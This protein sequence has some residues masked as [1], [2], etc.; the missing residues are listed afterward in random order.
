MVMSHMQQAKCVF[1]HFT[2]EFAAVCKRMQVG[3]VDNV[4]TSG[5]TLFDR[6]GWLSGG[7]KRQCRLSG[8]STVVQDQH[9][10]L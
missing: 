8:G 6:A 2:A 5:C 10:G 9:L 7:L 1:S 3:A 4:F